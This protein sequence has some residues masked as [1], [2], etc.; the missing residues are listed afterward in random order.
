MQ[1]CQMSVRG[2]VRAVVGGRLFLSTLSTRHAWSSDAYTQ[3][4]SQTSQI[5]RGFSDGAVARGGG[6]GGGGGGSSVPKVPKGVVQGD[7]LD[8]KNTSIIAYG[9]TS[10][11]I[12]NK[13]IRQS[14]ILMPETFLLWAPK[15][16]DE[17][18]IDSLTPMALLFP[19]LEV[20]FIGTGDKM[21]R[22][23]AHVVDHFR[24]KGIVIEASSTMN[25]AST[26]NLLIAEGRHV[27]AAL[28][29]LFPW[30]EERERIE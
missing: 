23:P 1:M 24:L 18:T 14:V 7:L 21:H 11:Q 29:T 12:D 9:D 5:Q 25:A 4:L 13:L 6:G 8:A 20:L 17:I 19:T 30:G 22:L 27:A 16:I 28:L 2:S 10:F 26:Y 15:S 3:R